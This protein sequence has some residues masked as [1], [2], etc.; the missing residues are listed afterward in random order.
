[1]PPNSARTPIFSGAGNRAAELLLYVG[2]DGVGKH[3]DAAVIPSQIQ[4]RFDHGLVR[5]RETRK[6][7]SVGFRMS[8]CFRLG[9]GMGMC[10]GIGMVVERAMEISSFV[11]TTQARTRLALVA[12]SAGSD[13]QLGVAVG[14]HRQPKRLHAAAH[15]FAHCRHGF[16]DRVGE[17]HGLRLTDQRQVGPQ[18]FLSRQR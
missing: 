16:A 7:A 3:V 15:R 5:C 13:G 11:A 17:D 10:I 9:M 8:M 12:T 18:I 4:R 6:G 2:E 1:M 14:I